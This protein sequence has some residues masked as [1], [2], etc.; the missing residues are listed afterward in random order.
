MTFPPEND[1]EKRFNETLK[2]MLGK[3]PLPH[4]SGKTKESQAQKKKAKPSKASPSSFSK[5]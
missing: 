5:R 1:D 2:R 4:D 3:P